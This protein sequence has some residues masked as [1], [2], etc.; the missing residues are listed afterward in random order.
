MT[1]TSARNCAGSD[2][3]SVSTTPAAAA[4]AEKE[5]AALVGAAIAALRSRLSWGP[6]AT[7]RNARPKL[8]SKVR[9]FVLDACE[10][11]A[12]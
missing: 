11:R 8:R 7:D 2:D 6:I 1:S 5:D 10:S 4:L 12:S 9:F 3:Q